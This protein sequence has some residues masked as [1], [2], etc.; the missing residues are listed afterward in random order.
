MEDWKEI[1][2]KMQLEITSA[3]RVGLLNR[4]NS[5]KIA[6]KNV[7][8][9]D[10]L[11]LRLEIAR[12]DYKQLL[13]ITQKQGAFVKILHSKGIYQTGKT[14]RKR[15]V[16]T[17]LCLFLFAVTLYLPSRVLFVQVEGNTSVSEK[18][19]T[20][21]AAE[22][23]IHFGVSRR[24]IRSEAIKN[25]LLQKIPQL[26]WAGINTSGC[27][28]VISV[29]EKTVQEHTQAENKGVCSIVAARDGVI[30]NCTVYEGNPLC[31]VGQAVKAGQT[32]VSGYTDCGIITTATR[33]NAEIRALTF[34]EL[35]I[36][37]PAATAIRGEVQRKKINY[38]IRIG[39]K[40][41]KFFKDSGNSDTTCVKI[42]S[43]NYVHLPGGFQLPLALIKETVCYLE[44]DEQVSTASESE[45]WL[46]D[47]AQKYLESTMVAGEV[48]SAQTQA[49]SLD[50]A[51][52][53][54][55]RYACMEMIGQ[56]KY[57]QTILEDGNND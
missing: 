20:E 7:L 23:G 32:L 1:F 49:R 9:C 18:Q 27:T 25:A 55:G 52:C 43:E 10:D 56:V 53:I 51:S 47:I 17:A 30:Q 8:Y 42:Y 40:V 12:A 41:I 33:A 11:V 14:I 13:E 26:Q 2:G 22:C 15:P 46:V 37:S 36:I 35:E 44:S 38:S 21:A 19:I 45:K 54:Y 24:N 28:A 50:N 31:T 6:V 39:K 4:L 29:R 34:R 5:E 3:D 48:I 16:L 57:E